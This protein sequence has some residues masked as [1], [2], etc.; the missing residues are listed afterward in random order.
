MLL[1]WS[2]RVCGRRA[3][4]SATCW[5]AAIFCRPTIGKSSARPRRS[6][7]WHLAAEQVAAHIALEHIHRLL[8]GRVVAA[9]ADAEGSAG[10]ECLGLGAGDRLVA[11][12]DDHDAALALDPRAVGLLL[13]DALGVVLALGVEPGAAAV[14]TVHGAGEDRDGH[15][16]AGRPQRLGIGLARLEADVAV[17]A[18]QQH[19]DRRTRRLRPVILRDA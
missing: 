13:E 8:G 4:I 14:E 9:A 5:P 2:A 16:G 10:L 1:C 17:R 12:A 18:A 7:N 11:L 15:I 19:V 3:T 6:I